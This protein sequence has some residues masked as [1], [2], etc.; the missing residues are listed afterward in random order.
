MKPAGDGPNGPLYRLRDAVAVLAN[1]PGVLLGDADRAS[2]WG[3]YYYQER[4][5]RELTGRVVR[6]LAKRLPDDALR[7]A[8]EVLADELLAY[9]EECEAGTRE[10]RYKRGES[11]PWP[12]M[13]E[14]ALERALRG[15]IHA[16]CMDDPGEPDT[17]EGGE[18]SDRQ[19]KRRSRR[20]A[21]AP[22]AQAAELAA[23]LDLERAAR[24]PGSSGHTAAARRCIQSAVSPRPITRRRPAPDAP[25]ED[26]RPRKSQEAREEADRA[27]RAQGQEARQQ[28][29]GRA[30]EAGERSARRAKKT[31]A[32]DPHL[33]P[34]LVWAGQGGAHEL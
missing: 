15:L 31:Y 30:R 8:R 9:L 13:S 11:P 22:S 10:R 1:A 34:Q 32:F 21:I 16:G 28:P 26:A 20:R 25:L 6:V 27:V 17:D 24:Q 18:V 29:A 12:S 33:D 19:P 23:R 4:G 5:A 3:A 2:R 14:S 7:A